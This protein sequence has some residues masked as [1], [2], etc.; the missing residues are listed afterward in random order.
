M[1]WVTV[2]F[3]TLCLSHLFPELTSTDFEKTEL[4]SVQVTVIVT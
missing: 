1:Q 3:P 2:H 4:T